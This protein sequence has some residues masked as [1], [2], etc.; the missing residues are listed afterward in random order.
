MQVIGIA[1]KNEKRAAM[2]EVPEVRVD[3]D[4]GLEGDYRGIS[5]L[6]QITVLADHGWQQ[7]CKEVG[8]KLAWTMRR[9]NIFVSY[10]GFGPEYLG[11]H[12]AFSG[13]VI[14]EITGET[15]P[16][17]RMDE[18]HQG[19]RTALMPEWRGGVTCRVVQGGTLRYMAPWSFMG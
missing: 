19:L 18:A 2:R 17:E 14:L 13:G 6:R 3:C 4:S 7:A 16:C 12:I 11:K 15:H 10:T 1:V 8:E 9:A 5:K